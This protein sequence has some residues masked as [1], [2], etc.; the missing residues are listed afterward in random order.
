MPRF[1]RTFL[2]LAAA[3]LAAVL[4][5]AGA[6]AGPLAAPAGDVILTVTGAIADTNAPGAAA[7]D[8]DGLM[9]LPATTYETSTI[10]TEGTHRFEGVLLKDL[11]AAVGGKGRLIRATALNDYT[12]EIPLDALDLDNALVAYRVD[13]KPMSVRNKGPL[14]IVYPFDRAAE[15]RSEVLYSRS[16]WQLATIDVR[17]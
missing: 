13:G 3:V 12:V 6:K 2:A 8:L 10:W 5:H 11:L 9:A 1:R 17:P 4:H 7:F 15:F 16:I 14:W